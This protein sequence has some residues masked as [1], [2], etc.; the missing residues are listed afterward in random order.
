MQDKLK[1][2]LLRSIGR[3][4]E[5]YRMIAAGDRIMVCLSGG[6]D[7]FALLTLLRDLQRRAPVRFDLLAVSLD[8]GF[9][10]F[11]GQAIENFLASEGL[12]FRIIRRNIFATVNEKLDP[13]KVACSLCS[14]LRRGALYNI[15]AEENCNKIAL[16]HHADDILETA[17]L[18]MFFTGAMKTMPPVLHSKDGRN[19]VIRPLAYCWERDIAAFAEVQNYPIASGN[20][21]GAQQNL[22]RKRMKKLIADLEEEIPELRHSMLAALGRI[23]PSHLLDRSLYKSTQ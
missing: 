7:S 12:A 2:L 4:I 15:A 20:P 11:P 8:Q 23:I 22:Q 16:G 18:N 1:K 10:D 5:D 21:C 17:L 3:A 19:I 6:K 9:P 13:G 14:R